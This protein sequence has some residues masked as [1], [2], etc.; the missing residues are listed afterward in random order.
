MFSCIIYS[1]SRTNVFFNN[2]KT[3]AVSKSPASNKFW[4]RVHSEVDEMSALN[5]CVCCSISPLSISSYCYSQCNSTSHSNR[6]MTVW[7][8]DKLTLG[9]HLVYA[10]RDRNSNTNCQKSVHLESKKPTAVSRKHFI[11]WFYFNTDTFVH[12]ISIDKTVFYFDFLNNRKH[13]RVYCPRLQLFTRFFYTPIDGK[14]TNVRQLCPI[15]LLRNAESI[16]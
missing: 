3:D 5:S 12:C 10:R 15:A 8:C 6:R 9:Q 16:H 1:D 13:L 2:G 4:K 14:I 7:Y 11:W